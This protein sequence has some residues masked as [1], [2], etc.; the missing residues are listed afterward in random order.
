MAQTMGQMVRNFSPEFDRMPV[1]GAN[2]GAA[3][4]GGQFEFAD[5]TASSVAVAGGNGDFGVAGMN[6]FKC[7]VNLKT[8]T[9]GTGVSAFGIQC[10][11]DAAFSTNL[12]TIAVVAIPFVA[13]QYCV[14]MSG[15]CPDGAEALRPRGLPAG[16]WGER[17]VRRVLRRMPI[18]ARIEWDEVFLSMED[19]Q[20]YDALGWPSR[21]EKKPME[22]IIVYGMNDPQLVGTLQDDPLPGRARPSGLL[23]QCHRRL[24][25]PGGGGQAAVCAT[26]LTDPRTAAAL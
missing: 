26:L 13:G 19:G 4:V 15:V 8:F 12:R 6:Y 2:A 1:G 17:H 23:E 20:W 9:Q 16:G 5:L 10:A 18:D 21:Q 22:S 7:S 24:A 25:E 3:L 11:D 14:H